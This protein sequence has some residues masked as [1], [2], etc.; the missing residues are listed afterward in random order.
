ML[1]DILFS[2]RTEEWAT[3]Q[4]FYDELNNEFNFVVDVAATKENAKAPLFFTKKTDGL[5]QSWDVGGGGFL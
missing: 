4:K 5:K 3:P 2:S 1:N